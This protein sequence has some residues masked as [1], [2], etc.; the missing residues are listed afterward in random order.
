MNR[1]VIAVCA[2]VV[3]LTGFSLVAVDLRAAGGPPASNP[4]TPFQEILDKLD[5]VLSAVAAGTGVNGK[6]DTV[7]AYLDYFNGGGAVAAWNRTFPSASR[8]VVLSDLNNEAFLDRE[9][10]LVWN[11]NVTF[12]NGVFPSG[13]WTWAARSCYD[14]TIGGRG[15]WRPSTVEE[16]TTLVPPTGVQPFPPD[17]VPSGI[18]S[19]M[20][21]STTVAGDTSKAWALSLGHVSAQ[22]KTVCCGAAVWCVRGGHGHDG[23]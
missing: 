3:A 6:L 9:T 8:F 5:Q 18:A 19:F 2:V 14:D 16:L 12:P 17:L 20:W 10:G 11:R 4:G 22:N 21:T 23:Q 7:L 1:R 13:N 15:G